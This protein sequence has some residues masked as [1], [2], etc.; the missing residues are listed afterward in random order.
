MGEV[1]ESQDIG[2]SEETVPE[3]FFGCES[4]SLSKGKHLLHKGH[5]FEGI[6]NKKAFVLEFY[7][8][9]GQFDGRVIGDLDNAGR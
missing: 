9:S 7:E 4:G 3:L 1:Y 5:V 2:S 8:Y 6:S